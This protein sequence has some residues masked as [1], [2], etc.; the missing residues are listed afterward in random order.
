MFYVF[1]AS[2]IET[3][4]MCAAIYLLKIKNKK[5]IIKTTLIVLICE[6]VFFAYFPIHS[7]LFEDVR[8]EATNTKNELSSG[9]E[10]FIR[11]I[12]LGNFSKMEFPK[13]TEGRWFWQSEMYGWRNENIDSRPYELT[14]QI[15]IEIPVGTDRDIVFMGSPW[16]GNV[17][18]SIGDYFV[19][20]DCYSPE[21]KDVVFRLPNTDTNQIILN[22]I[23]Q[24][25]GIVFLTFGISVIISFV[26]KR[27]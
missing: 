25:Q 1:L 20:I 22:Y 18:I 12:T 21:V 5:P 9:S 11:N 15:K 4:L 19:M 8:I 6:F 24:I 27:M 23:L 7:F 16:M 2:T 26:F 17:T 14:R 10:V 13:V 3:S